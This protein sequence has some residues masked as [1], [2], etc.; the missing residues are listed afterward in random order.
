MCV[1]LNKSFESPDAIDALKRAS[2]RW[3][4][5]HLVVPKSVRGKRRIPRS[6][7]RDLSEPAMAVQ[8]AEEILRETSPLL[9]HT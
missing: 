1:S 8:A 5:E 3:I 2:E 6:K 9:L 4:A 7:V